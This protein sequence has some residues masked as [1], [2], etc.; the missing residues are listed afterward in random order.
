MLGIIFTNLVEMIE[1]EISAEMADEILDEAD[2]STDGAYTSVGHYP[3]EDVLAIV[4][5]LSEKT[6]TPIP[7]LIFAFGQYLFPILVAGHKHILPENATLMDLLVQ[8]DS[9]IHV[10]VLKLYPNATLP[11]FTILEQTADN[12]VLEYSSPRQLDTLAAGLITGGSQYF[13]VD[14]DIAMTPLSDE[15]YRVKVDV[16]IREKVA[17]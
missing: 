2:L 5:L 1:T 13:G 14:I 16:K 10:E 4:T 17:N 8:L 11:T 9:N 12:I 15:P 3:F 6:D 7:D